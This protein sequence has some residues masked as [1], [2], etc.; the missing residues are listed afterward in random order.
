MTDTGTVERGSAGRFAIAIFLSSGLLFLIEPV[1]AKKI[2]PLL[3]GSAAVWAAC[4][5]FFQTALLGG[6]LA[7]HWLATRLTTR[8]QRGVY[9]VLIVASIIQLAVA[10]R[11][12]LSADSA[13]PIESVL[14]LLVLLIALPFVTLS[15]SGP[16]LQSW[17]ARTTTASPYRLYVIS[18]IGSLLGLL[19]YPWLIEPRASIRSQFVG[20]LVGMILF[21]VVAAIVALG[22]PTNDRDTRR[23]ANAIERDPISRRL[24]W[25][26]LAACGS[27]LLSAVTSYIS[28]N[29]ATI[30]LLWIIPLVAY[31]ASFIIAFADERWHPRFVV[32]TLALIGLAGSAWR[33]YRGDLRTPIPVTISIHCGALFA[34]CL[35]CHNELYLRRPPAQRLTSFYF[36]LA[37]GGAI[38][39]FLVGVVAPNVLVGNYDLAIGLTFAAL[40]AVVCTWDMGSLPRIV[41]LTATMLMASLVYRQDS[42]DAKSSIYRERN[43]YGTLRVDE[44][45]NAF[46]DATVRNLTHGIIEHGREVFRADLVDQP[47][48]YYGKSSGVGM[49]IQLCCPDRPRRIGVIG[50]GTGTIAA[51]G[52]P[53]D[54]IRFYD[55]NPAVEPI[56]RNIFTYVRHSKAKVDVVLGDAR[57]S[58]RNEA[59]QHYD[60]IAIDAFSGDAIPVHLITTEALE[61]YKRH[62]APGGVVAFHVSNRYLQLASVVRQLAEHAGMQAI[63][64]HT[65]DDD[66][67]AV[68]GAE[69]ILVTSNPELAATFKISADTEEVAIPPGLRRWTDDYNSLLPILRVR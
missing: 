44:V 51:F 62:L 58:M 7:A 20:L 12:E 56:A 28:Q 16:L 8:Q 24:I 19:V 27:F 30:P 54:V 34:L 52:R 18:N 17:Y 68:F 49:A 6:Y 61:L 33:L 50:L 47:T 23:D 42:I 37:A 65:E 4:L 46:F 3:G 35:F 1:A 59:P 57:V 36:H 9:L 39:A 2:L 29:V 15:S 69:W 60:V 64:I 26:A 40:L 14:R 25:I 10:S 11:I 41:A 63:G 48:T 53:G 66:P 32:V 67:H 21:G 22:V 45:H 13:R 31:L 5:V 55:L 43:F 38:G